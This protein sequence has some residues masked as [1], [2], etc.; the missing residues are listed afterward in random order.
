MTEAQAIIFIGLLF[1]AITTMGVGFI[2]KRP[3]WAFGGAV[4]WLLFGLNANTFSLAL[5]DI[6]YDMMILGVAMF[7]VALMEGFVIR[8]N[9]EQQDSS[10]DYYGSEVEQY[11]TRRQNFRLWGDYF[12]TIANGDKERLNQLKEKRRNMA[13]ARRSKRSDEFSEN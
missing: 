5:W 2:I 8:P 7:F 12:R 13:M 11:A 3:A 4:L 6:Y 9:P 10:E 1:A